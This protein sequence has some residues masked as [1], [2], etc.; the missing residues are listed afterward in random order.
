MIHPRGFNHWIFISM[1]KRILLFALIS[2]R[3]AVGSLSEFGLGPTSWVG[4]G[5]KGHPTAAVS[6]SVSF[7]VDLSVWV[8]GGGAVTLDRRGG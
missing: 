4:L 8:A 1:V 5:V 3:T 6:L 2:S 7:S